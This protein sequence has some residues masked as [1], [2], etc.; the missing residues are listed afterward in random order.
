MV[1]DSSDETFFDAASLATIGGNEVDDSGG[2][3]DE[4][5]D[6]GGVRPENQVSFPMAVFTPVV[7]FLGSVDDRTG[8]LDR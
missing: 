5:R 1:V 2:T 8:V 3:I 6:L 7:S 4:S